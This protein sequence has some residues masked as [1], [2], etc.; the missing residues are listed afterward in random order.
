[1]IEGLKMKILESDYKMRE[2]KGV[3]IS[4][5]TIKIVGRQKE[6]TPC[7]FKAR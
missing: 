7:F 3:E 6:R 4:A 2:L 5:S 1:M